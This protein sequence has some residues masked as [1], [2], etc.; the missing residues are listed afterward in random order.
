MLL[1]VRQLAKEDVYK[2]LVRIP[3]PHRKDP[4]GR[5]IRESTICRLSGDSGSA[6]V[7]VRGTI[8]ETEAIV[9]I[10]EK[11]R[12]D[13][14]VTDGTEYNFDIRPIWWVGQFWWAWNASDPTPRIR[15]RLG[16]LSLVL[17]VIGLLLGVLGFI[18]G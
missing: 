7:T 10:D 12:A 2:D 1:T 9:R 6:L 4:E 16:L 5:R 8:G 11:T 14:G 3:E 15:A 17:G 18:R 13:L